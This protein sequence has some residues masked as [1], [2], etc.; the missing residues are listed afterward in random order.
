M[1]QSHDFF[2]YS[3]K[4]GAARQ[5]LGCRGWGQENLWTLFSWFMLVFSS[6][7]H[8]VVYWYLLEWLHLVWRLRVWQISPPSWE[9]LV[10]I[11][12]HA[13][14][15]SMVISEVF[16]ECSLS[17]SLSTHAHVPSVVTFLLLLYMPS[18]FFQCWDWMWG[19]LYI[20]DTL[21]ATDLH[22]QPPNTIFLK[23]IVIEHVSACSQC[24]ENVV[25]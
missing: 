9:P 7:L 22:L 17:F 25:R 23:N 4:L 6:H 8:F 20:L 24:V 18:S 2:L 15:L 14:I 11:P 10:Y 12:W 1:K 13:N 19:A 16:W 5:M 21:S 3:Q